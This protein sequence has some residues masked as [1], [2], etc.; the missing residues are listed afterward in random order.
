MIRKL[1]FFSVIVGLLLPAGELQAGSAS[2]TVSFSAF[3][4]AVAAM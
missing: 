2:T 4:M 3:F 1:S